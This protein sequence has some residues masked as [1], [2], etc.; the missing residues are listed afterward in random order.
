MPTFQTAFK[1]FSFLKQTNKTHQNN[2]KKNKQTKTTQK[3]NNPQDTQ[4]PAYAI[5]YLWT[6]VKISMY[7]LQREKN[8]FLVAK[9][10]KQTEKSGVEWRRKNKNIRAS[11]GENAISW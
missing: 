4:L 11:Q 9:E 7:A 10:C 1:D 2:N 6:P 3:K 5:S 8:I